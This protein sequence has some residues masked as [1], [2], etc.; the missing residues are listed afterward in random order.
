MDVSVPEQSCPSYETNLPSTEKSR[1]FTVN[2]ASVSGF[3]AIG[4]GHVAAS[5]VFSFLGLSPINKNFRAE[6]IPIP[7]E[8]Y[9]VRHVPRKDFACCISPVKRLL[10]LQ[11]EP[12]LV[13]I[14]MDD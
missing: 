12:S 5:K 3:R 7:P 1:A 11:D 2:R 9:S 10:L 6:Q 8:K 13:N 14:N 4:G